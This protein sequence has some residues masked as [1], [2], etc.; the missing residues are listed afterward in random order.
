MGK[1]PSLKHYYRMKFQAIKNTN[2]TEWP[3]LSIC[4]NPEVFDLPQNFSNVKDAIIGLQDIETLKQFV[5]THKDLLL[6]VADQKNP[7]TFDQFIIDA[8]N[9]NSQ[10]VQQDAN[11]GY[12]P[13]G[14]PQHGITMVKSNTKE[15]YN[16][17]TNDANGNP[18]LI[19]K[20]TW[21]TF[22]YDFKDYGGVLAAKVQ[23]QN[24]QYWLYKN[25]KTKFIK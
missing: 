21:F 17:I 9:K 25:G 1:R 4:D 15:L 6:K 22:A 19:S 18:Y 11:V 24:K 13:V 3:S 2:S 10:Q 16:F 12:K 23:N 5:I 20:N 8:Q 14:Q 7:Y